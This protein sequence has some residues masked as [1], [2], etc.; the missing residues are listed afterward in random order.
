MKKVYSMESNAVDPDTLDTWTKLGKTTQK[1]SQR[2]LQLETGCPGG[3]KEIDAWGFQNA[4]EIEKHFH[5]LAKKEKINCFKE[6]IPT[7]WFKQNIKP[8]LELFGNKIDEND[9]KTEL[10]KPPQRVWL[11][12]CNTNEIIECF[13]QREAE[14][15]IR[16]NLPKHQNKAAYISRVKNGT[17]KS[18]IINGYKIFFEEPKPL[19]DGFPFGVIDV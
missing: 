16:P 10:A 14:F 6:W 1:I 19:K 17:R 7:S 11:R 18:N 12:N 3:I 8:H 4:D 5:N 9:T 15:I 13:S 2:K